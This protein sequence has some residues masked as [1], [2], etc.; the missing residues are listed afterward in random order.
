[1]KINRAFKQVTIFTAGFCFFIFMLG[2]AGRSDYNEEIIYTM[3][4][5]AYEDICVK[6]GDCSDQE[7]V[8]EYMS[9]KQYYDNLWSEK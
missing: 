9:N 6:L 8:N 7:I 2:M 1:M 4:Q 3:P 5:D